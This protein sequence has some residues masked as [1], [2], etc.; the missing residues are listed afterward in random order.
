MTRRYPWRPIEKRGKRE[1]FPRNPRLRRRERNRICQR[2]LSLSGGIL[3]LTIGGPET[4]STHRQTQSTSKTLTHRL[5][6]R[7]AIPSPVDRVLLTSCR[8]GSSEENCFV[9]SELPL[10]EFEDDL[11][12][13]SGVVVVNLVGISSG[14]E[15][16]VEMRDCNRGDGEEKSQRSSTKR[17]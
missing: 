13:D 17:E 16:D 11:V 3:I 5:V 7:L 4:E 10:E 14:M 9:L 6:R 1:E 8:R 2:G 15:L 12:V